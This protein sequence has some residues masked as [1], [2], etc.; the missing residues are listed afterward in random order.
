MDGVKYCYYNSYIL[1]Q[2]LR[3]I[4]L[5]AIVKAT[6]ASSILELDLQLTDMATTIN[7]ELEPPITKFGQKKP[8][9]AENWERIQQLAILGTLREL[10]I[11]ELQ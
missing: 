2:E 5:E 8:W 9:I 3:E 1:D 4:V 10:P 6:L 7:F 11:R